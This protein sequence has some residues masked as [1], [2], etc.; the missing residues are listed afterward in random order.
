[1]PPPS[2][3]FHTHLED[4]L[5]VALILGLGHAADVIEQAEEALGLVLQQLE[6]VAVVGV[7]DLLPLQPFLLVELLLLLERVH[8]P[9]EAQRDAK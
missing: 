4:A 6:A 5:E 9:N 1:M 3:R 2:P 8:L 7:R